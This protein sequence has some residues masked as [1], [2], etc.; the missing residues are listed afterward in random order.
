VDEL[1]GKIMKKLAF[2]RFDGAATRFGN[3]YM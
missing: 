3:P 2:D 1:K